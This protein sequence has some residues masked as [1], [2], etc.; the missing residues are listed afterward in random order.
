MET[1][2]AVK[3][4]AQKLYGMIHQ[5]FIQTTKGLHLMVNFYFGKTFSQKQKMTKGEFGY[6]PRVL[7]E[8]QA[9]LPWGETDQIDKCQTRVYCPKCKG[10]FQPD[11]P[12]HQK[13]DGAFF[14]PNFAPILVM[15]YPK[16]VDSSRPLTKHEPNLYGFKIAQSSP[17]RPKKV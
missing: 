10:L 9:V 5:R 17:I 16:A 13:V 6:C 8:K 2:L 12:R 14:G 1:Q 3:K 15:C 4:E 7:C 11:Y